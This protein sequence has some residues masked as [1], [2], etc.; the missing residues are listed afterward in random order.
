VAEFAIIGLGR[1]GRAVARSLAL[2]GQ[3]VLAVD[4]DPHRLE[5]VADDVDAVVVA[6]TTD[7]AKVA[8]LQLGRMACVVVTMGSR[9]LEASLLTTAIL[10]EQDVP[11]VVARAFDERHARL[12]LAV[13]A[14][15]V[16]NP[17]DEIG[18]R[19]ALRLSHPGIVDQVRLGEASI[20]E[21]EAPEAFA[22]HCLEELD[23]RKRQG[24]T[25]L[26]IRRGGDILANPAG[27]ARVESGDVLV[28]LGDPEAVRELGTLR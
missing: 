13:G 26:A 28:L 14:N 22:G 18:R 25:V 17:E 16:I 27:D 3:A 7:E 24:L 11:R 9:A 1:F 21:V 23:L 12:L 4:R 8:S 19:L 20:A 15:E 6:D 10:R 5:L 2:E